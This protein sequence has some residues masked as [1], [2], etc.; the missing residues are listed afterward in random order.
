M[1]VQSGPDR[2]AASDFTFTA[3]KAVS[4]LAA[5]ANDHSRQ[6]VVQ[7]HLH[8]VKKGIASLESI[9]TVRMSDSSAESMPAR[10]NQPGSGAVQMEEPEKK[11]KA[12]VR[13][14]TNNLAAALFTHFCTRPVDGEPDPNLHTHCIIPRLSI[15]PDGKWA[16][17]DIDIRENLRQMDGVYRDS[18]LEELLLLGV[19]ATISVSLGIAIEGVTDPL[20]IAFSRRSRK[21]ATIAAVEYPEA[22]AVTR[23]AIA[24]SS[25]EEKAKDVPWVEWIPRWQLRALEVL[26]KP[27]M[28]AI[29]QVLNSSVGESLVLKLHA[30]FLTK[31]E[32]SKPTTPTLKKPDV[33][34]APKVADRNAV[35]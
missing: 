9:V 2:T 11:K 21:I 30:H 20:L 12:M 15:R 22:D 1:Q 23:R 27:H 13:V 5:L 34:F 29:K 3:P 26:D 4:I 25:R 19:P 18:L 35:G 31:T 32:P 6:A 10:R 8:A 28:D 7:A 33:S 14:R 24:I 17:M 16:T